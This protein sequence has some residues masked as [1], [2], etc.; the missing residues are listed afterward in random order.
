MLFGND[1]NAIPGLGIGDLRIG[2]SLEAVM[3]LADEKHVYEDWMGGN[4]ND[5]LLFRGICLHFDNCDSRS[6][7][8]GSKLQWIRVHDRNDIQLFDRPMRSWE[9][10]R[11]LKTLKEHGYEVESWSNSLD[12]EIQEPDHMTFGFDDAGYL[13][14]FDI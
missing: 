8:P 12:F 14:A 3:K 4:L 13:L 6:P 2:M 1:R 11:L 5:A 9:H 7:L 10:G